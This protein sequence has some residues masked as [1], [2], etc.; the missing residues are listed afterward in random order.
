MK[1]RRGPTTKR[2]PG[3]NRCALCS[4]LLL[5]GEACRVAAQVKEKIQV[6]TRCVDTA[7]CRRRRRNLDAYREQH[8]EDR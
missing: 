7:G 4:A 8:G 5:P 1:S 2:A 3:S 6:V